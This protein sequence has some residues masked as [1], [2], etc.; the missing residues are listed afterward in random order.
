MGLAILY[1][2]H[3]ISTVRYLCDRTSVMYAGRVVETGPTQ[4]LLD[5]PL[6]PYTQALFAAVPVMNPHARRSRVRLPGEV[7]SPT[8]K[9]GGCFFHPRC[10]KAFSPCSKQSPEL[11]EVGSDHFVAC[12]LY[13]R[14]I[15]CDNE[16]RD[17]SDGA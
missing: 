3:D 7:P 4:Q 15:R 17:A 11:Y 6:H 16:P 2:S 5:K 9:P 14:H 1:I 13:S 10:E 8:N 12:H